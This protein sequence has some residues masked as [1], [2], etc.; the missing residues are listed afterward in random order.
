M[1]WQARQD[2]HGGRIRHSQASLE[3]RRLFV[4]CYSRYRCCNIVLIGRQSPPCSLAWAGDVA[5]VPLI[6]NDPVLAGLQQ[7]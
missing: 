1:A 4:L 2:S 3:N 6:W 5:R 7:N